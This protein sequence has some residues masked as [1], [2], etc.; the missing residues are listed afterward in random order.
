LLLVIAAIV[1]PLCV[2]YVLTHVLE[3]PGPVVAIGLVLWAIATWWALTG[4]GDEGEAFGLAGAVVLLGSLV[5]WVGGV[6][7]AHNRVSSLK[8][9]SEPRA[10]RD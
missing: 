7:R 5:G 1:C 2:A 6:S 8:G 9:E 4:P 3:R 10:P